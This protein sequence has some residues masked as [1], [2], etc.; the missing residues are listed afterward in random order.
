MHVW[1]SCEGS[2]HLLRWSG[3]IGI[4]QEEDTR[5]PDQRDFNQTDRCVIFFLFC[6]SSRE[7]CESEDAVS[8]PSSYPSSPTEN[9]TASTENHSRPSS[10]STLEENAY[11]DITGKCTP[12][13]N[14][15]QHLPEKRVTGS[16]H[17]PLL[18]S[19][20]CKFNYTLTSGQIINSLPSPAPCSGPETELTRLKMLPKI[21]N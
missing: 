20:V 3:L 16:F 5:E 17:S 10:K 11:E 14:S 13:T 19:E 2:F 9:G 21:M 1:P 6:L 15:T 7:S 4:S 18:I 12:S 8:L